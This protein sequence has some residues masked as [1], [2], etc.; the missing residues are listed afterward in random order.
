MKS[1]TL[2]SSPECC[3]CDDALEIIR[4]VAI[5]KAITAAKVNIFE[6]K[7]LLVKYRFTIPVVKDPESNRE[8][9]WPFDKDQFINWVDSL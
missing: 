3:L 5:D 1:L 8:I 2:Y 4:E 7:Q 6:D 9:S